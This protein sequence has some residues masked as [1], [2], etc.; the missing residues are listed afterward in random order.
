MN[1]EIKLKTRSDNFILSL[2]YGAT[3]EFILEEE[4]CVSYLI[5]IKKRN[6]NTMKKN[7][8]FLK[9]KTI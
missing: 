7:V 4:F 2:F 9:D 5:L 8:L 6:N 1:F 3:T